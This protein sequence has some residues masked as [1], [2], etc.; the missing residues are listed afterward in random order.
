MRVISLL[1]ALAGLAGPAVAATDGDWSTYGHDK[2]SQRHSPLTQITPANV[3]QLQPAW[4]YHMKRPGDQESAPGEPPKPAF[5]GSEMT[6]LVVNGHMFITTPYGRV[7]SLDPATGQEQWVTPIAGKG[8]L[9]FRGVEYWPG[10]AKTAPRIVFGTGDGRL[11]ELDAATGAFVQDFADK[12]VLDLKTPEVMNGFPNGDYHMTSPPLVAGDIVVTGARVQE[13]PLQGPSGDVRAWNVRTGK[14]LWTFHTIPRP[15]EPNYGTWAPGSDDKRS[16]VNVWG[17]MSVDQK[18]GILYLPVAG[19]TYDR[20]GGDRVGDDLYGSSLVALNLKTGKYLWHFQLVHHDIWDIDTQGAP[21]LFDAKIHGHTIP[22]VSITTKNAMLFM[23]NRVTGKP[24]R[25][26]VERPVPASE[27]PGEVASPTQ[28]FPDTPPLSRTSFTYP[29][30]IA[31]VTPQLKAQCEAFFTAGKMRGTVQYEPYHVDTPGV[32]FPGTEGGAD[33]DGQ[34]YDPK[35]DLLLIPTNNM[36]LVSSLVKSN[37]PT[38]YRNVASYFMLPD[39]RLLCQKPPWSVLSAVSASTGK[40]VW[41]SPMGQ[42]D[43]LPEGL[44]NTG[45]PGH[46][47]A[48]TTAS[49]LVFIGF[50]DDARFHAFNERTGEEL[51][52]YKLPAAAHATPITYL[53]SDGRQY[54]AVTSTGGSYIASPIVGDELTAFALPK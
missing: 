31:D 2:G 54:V 30:D 15:G 8:A 50:G 23:F 49:G 51:W 44:R 17:F 28:P 39:S 9:S 46:G 36:A 14:L 5:L 29:D 12:G 25:P 6:P 52:T 19:A 53:G 41:Q 1:I 48:I 42:S 7:A 38:A 45:R 10:D 22:A 34:A 21:L 3:A 35:T 11:I 4:V 40:I 37:G 13:Y 27:T 24:L 43:N 20:Y 26:I 18:R 47:G 32:H 33:W 16:G